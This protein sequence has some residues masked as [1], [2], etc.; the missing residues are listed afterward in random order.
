MVATKWW[1]GS[2]KAVLKPQPSD[3]AGAWAVAA[4]SVIVTVSA[5][6]AVWS[7]RYLIWPLSC[8]IW[9]VIWL[10]WFC[11]AIMSLIVLAWVS[12]LSIAARCAMAL[13][14][15]VL[16]PRHCPVTL[17]PGARSFLALPLLSSYLPL[18]VK[19][20]ARRVTV[21]GALRFYSSLRDG[22]A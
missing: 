3:G 20:R 18:V 6:K 15:R 13:S 9:P 1:A 12:R 11:T 16:R 4:A 17:L 22:V 10:I 8:S 5:L 14:R 19:M 2:I 21:W 7:S